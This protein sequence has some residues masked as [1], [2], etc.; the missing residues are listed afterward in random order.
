MTLRE[1]L[2]KIAQP[3][4][5]FPDLSKEEKARNRRLVVAEFEA[6]AAL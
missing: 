4:D 2:A 6:S 5:L 3:Y 1:K